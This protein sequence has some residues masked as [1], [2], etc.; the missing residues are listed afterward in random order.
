[1]YTPEPLARLLVKHLLMERC[2]DLSAD[3][4]LDLKILEPAMGSAAFL[5]ETTNQL[6]D[7]YLERKQREVGRTIPQEDIV[8]EKQRV[9][10]YIADRNCFGVDLNPT[11]VELGAI[12]LW[13]NGLHKGD[14]SPWFGDQLHA[15]NSLIGAR[16]AVYIPSQ[17]KGKTADLWFNHPPT[18]LGWKEERPDEDV[19]QWLLPAKDMAAFE[20]DKS[21]KSFAGEY[22]ERIKKWR[23]G[24]FF[25]PLEAHEISLV[26]RL[27]TAADVLFSIVA[28]EL[29]RTRN[30]ANDE[31]TIWPEQLKA[32]VKDVDYHKKEL[33]KQRLMGEDHAHNT[34]PFKRL[35]TAMDA[36]CALWLWPIEQADK[37]P[38]RQEFFEGMRVLLEGGFSADGSFSLGEMDDFAVL[39]DDLFG[40][41]NE[42]R[43]TTAKYNTSLFQET[44][45]E[46][47]IEE[48]DWLRVAGDVAEQA[49][50]VHYDLLFAD[51]LKERKGFD[52]VVGNPPWAK[53]NWNEGA[54][55]A[56]IDPIYAGKSASEI[57]R[58]L[59]AAL[60][61]VNGI[62]QFLADY[63]A[64]KGMI[65]VSASSEMQ[66]Y[67]GAGA[68]NLY[69]C[70]LSLIFRLLASEA[71]AGV[72]HQDGHLTASPTTL[73]RRHWYGRIARHFDF[74]NKMTGKMFAEVHH[75][76]MF[77]LNIYRGELGDVAFDQ[78]TSAFLPSQVEDSYSDQEGLGE[79]PGKKNSDGE[80]D[81]R[82]HKG[83]VIR[84]D[85][86]A[87]ETI[88]ALSEDSSIPVEEARFIQP[89]SNNTLRIFEALASKSKI[90]IALVD[91]EGAPSWQMS[92]HWDEAA[93]QKANVIRRSTD[94]RSKCRV[95]QGPMFHVANP[96]YKNP[97]R[98]SKKN[99]DYDLVDLLNI[100]ESYISRTNFTAVSFPSDFH[101]SL[102][103]CSWD[104]SK[105]QADFY[106]LAVREMIALNGER[107]FISCV[108]PPFVSHVSSIQS[109]AFK[110]VCDLLNCAT[111]AHS[112][113]YDFYYKASSRAHFQAQDFRRMP[114][115]E[116][117]A[118]A[119]QRTLFL[120]CLTMDFRDLWTSTNLTQNSKIVWSP[121]HKLY[122]LDCINTQSVSEW[123]WALP[124]RAEFYRRQALVEIDVVVAQ[125]F[126]VRLEQLLEMYRIY[127]PVLQE[128]EAAT[129]Y[130]Q[131][132]RIVWS[133][134][135]GLPGVGYLNEKGKSPGR[136]EWE[137]ILSTNPSELVCTAIDD[138]RP[139]G[140][141]EVE[142]RFVGPFFTCD[143]AE[144]YK[145]AWAHFE[146]VDSENA[147]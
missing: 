117:P 143:R 124:L 57:R 91:Y 140:P 77:S 13:L 53:P 85:R 87:L 139:G 25:K 16:R 22:Q 41:E 121:I 23:A 21:I 69:R 2:E 42:V 62:S 73:L 74:S 64:S 12:S 63:S 78:F 106:R 7:L 51:I 14:F 40:S 119:L 48:Y 111:L 122:G 26:K 142:R 68:N 59:P 55:L 54:V 95:I 6:A 27:S 80:W 11:A 4:L 10:S 52:L 115:V 138:T 31:I 86:T 37:L 34:L 5:V 136:R 129:W 44:N 146:K 47:L 147:A 58:L 130:D 116:L 125:A 132:G 43:D 61:R 144:D 17:L 79:I 107:S 103:R 93:A 20:K 101:Q 65:S 126:G 82:G 8:I 134:S 15:G 9:R 45:V 19:F 28:D 75:E 97:T 100:N 127:F 66:P 135:K 72:I 133:C 33:L 46:A 1:Y 141:Y 96:I 92:S 70:F 60:S 123:A 105:S 30:A 94:F 128:N 67:V 36:W 108:I 39:Q 109:I 49:R 50:F 32:G 71:F 76:L 3:E 84:I 29:A 113:I 118:Y 56:D 98:N 102:P 112:I 38:N 35:K 120:N 99:A 24:G 110:R 114:F 137:S 83:R 90:G 81:T 88:H 18:E 104:Q 131:N 89:F 145:R